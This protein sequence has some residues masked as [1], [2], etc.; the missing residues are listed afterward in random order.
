MKESKSL[1]IRGEALAKVY[2]TNRGYRIIECN[3]LKRC[4]EI[5]I[6]AQKDGIIVFIEVKTR[7]IK[8]NFRLL[9]SPEASV[10]R[11]KIKKIKAT[12][13]EF[14]RE[15][16]LSPDESYRFDVVSVTISEGMEKIKHMKY[17]F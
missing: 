5:D 17:A 15:M 11:I 12:A 8:N 2:L 3:Y 9:E 1:G 13:L 7:I 16:K 4:G 6:I 10:S 14:I